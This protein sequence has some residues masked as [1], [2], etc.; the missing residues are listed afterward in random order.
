MSQKRQCTQE[1][2]LRSSE[3]R[4][5][6]TRGR[7]SALCISVFRSFLQLYMCSSASA[8]ERETCLTNSKPLSSLLCAELHHCMTYIRLQWIWLYRV[9]SDT[10]TFSSA[11]FLASLW[12]PIRISS[13]T[14]CH[15]QQA[16]H[17]LIS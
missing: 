7:Y 16:S 11:S 2:V 17:R 13:G 12:S 4:L 15:R 9:R 10:W 8:T 5:G 3:R 6:C 1:C 14:Y